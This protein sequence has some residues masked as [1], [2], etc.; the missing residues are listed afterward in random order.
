[1]LLYILNNLIVKLTNFQ[2][3]E[4]HWGCGCKGS[5]DFSLQHEVV[6]RWLVLGFNSVYNEEIHDTHFTGG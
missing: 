3:I 2:A 5:Q 1:M 4:V 6:V